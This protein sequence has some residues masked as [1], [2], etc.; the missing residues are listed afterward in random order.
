MP[1]C[2]L[3]L[4]VAVVDLSIDG[5]TLFPVQRKRLDSWLDL[6][7]SLHQRRILYR[8]GDRIRLSEGR[9]RVW[10]DDDLLLGKLRIRGGH[11]CDLLL[12]D[13]RS[14]RNHNLFLRHG[15]GR[16]SLPLCGLGWQM[17]VVDLPIRGFPLF[18]SRQQLR[19]DQLGLRPCCD[20]GCVVD[21]VRPAVR[22]DLLCPTLRQLLVCLSRCAAQGREAR[23]ARTVGVEGRRGDA[24]VALVDGDGLVGG[25]NGSLADCFSRA[26]CL[27]AD[28]CSR[29]R[30]D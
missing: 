9:G 5:L 13:G 2:R 17:A 11:Y 21:I 30:G 15:R 27:S 3:S 28:R 24:V 20:L 12:K 4:R 23:D 29:A 8:R 10:S 18:P 22:R 14:G 26:D 6:G 25:R 1:L 16:W 7:G 19:G